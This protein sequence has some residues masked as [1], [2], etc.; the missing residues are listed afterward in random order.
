MSEWNDW[1]ESLPDEVQ[2]IAQ[3][4]QF[5]EGAVPQLQAAQQRVY[6]YEVIANLY[7]CSRPG[8]IQ[9]ILHHHGLDKPMPEI[10]GDV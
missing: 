4:W 3:A 10:E 7:M 6:G 5:L 8:F 1:V 2:V 9:A